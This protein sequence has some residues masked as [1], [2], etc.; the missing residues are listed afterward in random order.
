MLSKLFIPSHLF[1]LI[2]IL[3]SA[4][5]FS[6]S[7]YYWK[8][9][10][11]NLYQNN[12]YGDY[13]S[14][15]LSNILNTLDI[16]YILN[17]FPEK[18][19]NIPTETYRTIS[20][21]EKYLARIT[22]SEPHI[23]L[24][25]IYSEPYRILKLG[26][27]FFI[28]GSY[29]RAIKY[30]LQASNYKDT[31]KQA[32]FS[33]I[34]L[35]ETINGVDYALKWCRERLEDKFA[36]DILLESVYAKLGEL[37]W[38]KNDKKRSLHYIKT[39]I[40]KYPDSEL[41]L[42][43]DISLTDIVSQSS[44]WSA[45]ARIFLSQKH[46]NNAI[47]LLKK[48][49]E[50]N[51]ADIEAKL[52]LGKTYA[53]MGNIEEGIK[54]IEDAIDTEERIIKTLDFVE[55]SLD[56]ST[57]SSTTTEALI[58]FEKMLFE[59]KR[60]E[61]LILRLAELYTRKRI[62]HRALSIYKRYRDIIFNKTETLINAA[63]CGIETGDY[64][65]AEQCLQVLLKRKPEDISVLKLAID[66]FL[67]KGNI[68]TAT[69]YANKLSLLFPRDIETLKQLARVYEKHNNSELAE[70]YYKEALEQN[71]DDDELLTDIGIFYDE[72]DKIDIAQVFLMKATEKNP[73]NLRAWL[74]LG[75]IH[76]KRGNHKL[77]AK[78]FRNIVINN[79][80]YVSAWINLA[81]TYA[82]MGYIE[83]AIKYCSQAMEKMPENKEIREIL[84]NLEERRKYNK[85]GA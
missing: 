34:S 27:L 74:N 82:E 31:K 24:N 46:Y 15:R 2:N 13:F 72:F 61:E 9:K 16:P 19:E 65:F 41:L 26:N 4:A 1:T 62:F 40:E 57:G 76:G 8:Y 38:K 7:I 56:K 77:A 81:I 47:N 39:F 52:L 67:E 17:A 25:P 18:S 51:P 53:D 37:Y 69:F 73:S 29:D 44:F 66:L 84:K 80:Y 63:Q 75:I 50:E 12:Q 23:S 21:L 20:Y 22:V 60:K 59:E 42:Y 35:Y 48:A 3:F 49:L 33:L 30:L 58:I 55:S 32:I 70:K 45:A 78:I 6:T 28:G 10:R 83:T 71:P 79:P 68:D 11:S 85:Y 54:Y 5:I 43:L 14:Y 36:D 64:D